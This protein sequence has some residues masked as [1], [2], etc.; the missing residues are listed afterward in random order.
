MQRS[1]KDGWK[2]WGRKRNEAEHEWWNY[3]WRRSWALTSVIET[4]EHHR[5]AVHSS[6]A[7]SKKS[8]KIMTHKNEEWRPK[9]HEY[10]QINWMLECKYSRKEFRGGRREREKRNLAVEWRPI[11]VQSWISTFQLPSLSPDKF[12][13]LSSSSCSWAFPISP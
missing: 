7:M 12:W 13:L 11:G 8:F 5:V 6:T 10:G 2:T 9:Q 3:S 4:I 1:Y